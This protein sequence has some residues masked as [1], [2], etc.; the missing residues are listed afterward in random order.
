MY[1]LRDPEPPAQTLRRQRTNCSARQLAI[2]QILLL[3]GTPSGP[4]RRPRHTQ[5]TNVATTTTTV[6]L[7]T[8]RFSFVSRCLSLSRLRLIAANQAGLVLYLCFGTANCSVAVADLFP[9]NV[10]RRYRQSPCPDSRSLPVH[11]AT[12]EKLLSLPSQETIT[13]PSG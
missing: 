5:T 1:V 11:E 2:Y 4:W 3:V 13:R 8:R 6:A 9:W 12:T 10:Y 7:G